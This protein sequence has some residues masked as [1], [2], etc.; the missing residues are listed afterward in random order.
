M[1]DND[2]VFCSFENYILFGKKKEAI[3]TF[4][5]GTHMRKTQFMTNDDNSTRGRCV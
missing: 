5:S 2:Y 3:L 4:C 1:G